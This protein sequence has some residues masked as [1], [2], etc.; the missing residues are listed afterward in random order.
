M[1]VMIM[2]PI[3]EESAGGGGGGRK[4][5][6]L[7]DK[8]KKKHQ[9]MLFELFPLPVLQV[10]E[11]LQL[12]S[13]RRPRTQ[14]SS[15]MWVPCFFKTH[16]G[17]QILYSDLVKDVSSMFLLDVFGIPNFILRPGHFF[18]MGRILESQMLTPDLVED[19]S[20]IDAIRLSPNLLPFVNI[21]TYKHT[22]VQ[23]YKST[24]IQRK[25]LQLQLNS[26][27]GSSFILNRIW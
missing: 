15:K 9:R 21:Q 17:S 16:L 22:K 23:T 25:L 18:F 7:E 11:C 24:K 8:N 5:H 6:L 13:H 12:Q 27:V 14:T 20:Q 3:P 4:V 19:V 26:D 2:I 10:Q 1:M